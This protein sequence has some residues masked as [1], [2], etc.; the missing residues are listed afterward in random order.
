MEN[1]VPKRNMEFSN[2]CSG[3]IP[4]LA[5]SYILLPSY[6]KVCFAY[7]ALFPK[8]YEFKKQS[9]IQLWMTEN[10]PHCRQHIRTPEEVCQQ[11]FN[12]LLSRSFFQPLDE[13]KKVFDMQHFNDVLSRSFFQQSDKNKEVF[14]MHDLL[15]DLA[16]Y[17]GGGLYFRC[18]LDQ[19]EN[20]EKVTRH[21]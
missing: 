1:C 19:T 11:Y 21:F 13:N 5:L 6:L 20:I 9:L 4:S 10:F 8:D 3:I 12:D 16:N 2:E 15:L 14:V 7:C 18:E 17:V